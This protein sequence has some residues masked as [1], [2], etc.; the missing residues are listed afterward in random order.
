MENPTERNYKVGMFIILNGRIIS[1]FT[2]PLRVFSFRTIVVFTMCRYTKKIKV[3]MCLRKQSQLLSNN[4]KK[5]R[6]NYEETH[7][8][9]NGNLF[10]GEYPFWQ[11]V[12]VHLIQP[13][14]IHLHRTRQVRIQG[15]R[16]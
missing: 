5:E 12:E 3:T 10:T 7:R 2:E 4:I 1:K 13:E 11:A 9:F 6:Q 14:Q 16:Q 8:M 15:I